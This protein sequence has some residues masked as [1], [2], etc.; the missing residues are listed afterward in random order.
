MPLASLRLLRYCLV[1]VTV[2]DQPQALPAMVWI[3]AVDVIDLL[4]RQRP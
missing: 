1:L 3:V 4:I 2:V